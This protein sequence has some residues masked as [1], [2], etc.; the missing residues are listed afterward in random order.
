MRWS[1]VACL[2]SLL[3][4]FALALPAGAARPRNVI[5]CIGDGMGPVQ[6]EAA[7]M[8]AGG[9]MS[10]EA[11]PFQ[12]MVTTYSANSSVTDSAAAATAMA[13]GQK[14]NNGVIS[15]A[16]PGDGSELATALELY[17]ATGRATGLVTTTYMTHATPAAY[18]AHEPSRGNTSQIA[19][20]YLTQTLPNVLLGGGANGMSSG[21][22]TAAGYTVVTDHAGLVGLDTSTET[23]VSGQFGST[24]LPY[25]W[26]QS[27]S[28]HLSEMTGVA[29]DILDNDADGFFLMV[30]GGR[31]DH[32]GHANHIQ[33][34]I[35][36]TIEFSDTVDVVLDWAATRTDTLVI[37]TADHETGGLSIDQDNGAGSFP[38]VS[39]ST[40]G[41][42]GV[43]VPIYAW[44]LN[45]RTV[46]G[47][48][49]NTDVFTLSMLD[50]PADFDDDGDV[51]ADDIDALRANLG[52]D[53]ATYDLDGSGIVDEDDIVFCVTTVLSTGMGDFNL[54]RVVDVADLT[55]L[56][57]SSGQSGM[58]WADG[59]A[60]GDDVVDIADLTILRAGVGTDWA[61]GAAVP[62]PA[63]V[64]VMTAAL[65]V[66]TLRRRR[67]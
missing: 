26:D 17:Q 63:S 19:N 53:P 29:L 6:V 46:S 54:D 64:A 14:V 8:Y 44:G 10:F 23:Y 43:D 61:P 57:T 7:G 38:D 30:E 59:N 16:Y 3:C 47:T 2:L 51:D 49:D 11:L 31:I 35:F 60:N 28:V 34:N 9:T 48:I 52:G 45:A 25:E 22:A 12:G 4:V 42:T 50:E 58:A 20:D 32:A 18:G 36:E 5:V 40:G 67:S 66:S 56:R 13:T 27:P 24:H 41:H 15:M 1:K 33:R 37:V 65:A 55:T 62:E 21:A 39:W